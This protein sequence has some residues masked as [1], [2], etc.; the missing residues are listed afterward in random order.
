MIGK[1]GAKDYSS[2]WWRDLPH[3]P[4]L[5][6]ERL[7]DAPGYLSAL[8]SPSLVRFK[9]RIKFAHP[10]HDQSPLAVCYWGFMLITNLTLSLLTLTQVSRYCHRRSIVCLISLIACLLICISN[11]S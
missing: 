8:P 7:L 5:R 2:A 3:I 10:I 6:W 4:L 1:V 9:P 11:Q